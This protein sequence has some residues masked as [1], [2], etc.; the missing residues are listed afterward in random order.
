MRRHHVLVT[1]GL[2]AML[3][4]S[5]TEDLA[6]QCMQITGRLKVRALEDWAKT[7]VSATDGSRH[8]A[9]DELE[10]RG[11]LGV[12]RRLSVLGYSISS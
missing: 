9:F 5:D 7:Q 11:L 3:H 10:E 4:L 8:S 12:L 6:R 2:A 1:K